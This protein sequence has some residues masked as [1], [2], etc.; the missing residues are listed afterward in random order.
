[1]NWHHVLIVIEKQI[2]Y[3]YEKLNTIKTFNLITSFLFIS[4][5]AFNQN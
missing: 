3:F 5:S 1:L 4:D 2:V